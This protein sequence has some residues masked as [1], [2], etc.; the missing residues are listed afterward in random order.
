MTTSYLPCEARQQMLLAH[1]LQDRLPEG[2]LAYFISDTVDGLD[3]QALHARYAQG[4]P[5]VQP[6]HP[7]MMVKVMGVV[8]PS[9]AAVA[10]PLGLH[11]GSRSAFGADKHAGAG[12][13]TSPS[14]AARFKT[15]CRPD[16]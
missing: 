12:D 3:L 5:R 16:S 4:G 9:Q 8:R 10:M 2:H 15:I 14:P 1:A 11:G 13:T 6:F 7:A